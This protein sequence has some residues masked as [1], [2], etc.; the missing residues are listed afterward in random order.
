MGAD[1][2]NI[3]KVSFGTVGSRVMGLVRDSATMAYMGIGAV[4]A[5]YTFAFTLP[6]LFRRLLGEGALTSALIPIFSQTLKNDGR[7]NAFAFL[8]R[9]LTRGGILM[10]VLAVLG[11]LAAVCAAQFFDAEQQRFLLGASFSAVLMP[12]LTLVCL[13]AVFSGA[14]N[15]LGS[16]GVPS[17]TPAL[18][19]LS[20]I[21]GLAAGV[22]LFGSEDAVSIAYCMCAGWLVGGFIQLALPAYWL[23]KCGWKFSFDLS[24]SPALS[25]LYALFLPALVGAAV[26]QLNVFVSKMLALF[27]NDA[28]L[29]TLYLSS[30]ILE[31]P[32]GVFTLA[33]ATVYFPKLS[34]LGDSGAEFR[35]EYSNGLVVTM[36]IAI[37]AMFGIIATSRD[38]LALLFEWGLFGTKDVDV[39]LPVLIVSVIGL[40]FFALSTFATRGFHSTKD[41]RTPVK[42]SYWAFAANVALSLALMFPFGA[43]GLAGANVG[44]AA[45]QALMLDAKLKRKSGTSGECR[46]ILKI[47]AASAAMACAVVAARNALAETLS[48]KTLAFAVCAVV[49]PVACVFYYAM[50]KILRF[51]RTENI[52]KILFRKIRK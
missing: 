50:L 37:P 43:A 2:K 18:H 24:P 15:A 32:L 31:F 28:A 45:L 40:P 51:K 41:T 47:V 12:Y 19:N 48:G 20:I 35:R 39:C 30:R 27:L 1:L 33:I 7:E 16:F 26:F 38:I 29:P 44:A 13:A 14:L 6:N 10:A 46:E 23:S 5:A 25:E 9:V 21:G 22:A 34:K 42:V 4:S 17:I 3:A 8:N 36:G 49:I 11:S 52:E